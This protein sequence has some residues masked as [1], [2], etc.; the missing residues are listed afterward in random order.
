M[1]YPGRAV[2]Q[3]TR[4]PSDC[5]LQ[6][7]VN[8]KDSPTLSLLV[9][10]GFAGHW[11]RR[12]F[13]FP[14]WTCSPVPIPSDHVVLLRKLLGSAGSWI[15][16]MRKAIFSFN[17]MV[18]LLN[19]TAFRRRSVCLQHPP[20]AMRLMGLI[21][22]ILWSIHQEH[23]HLNTRYVCRHSALS[24]LTQTHPFL[25]FSVCFRHEHWKPPLCFPS[26]N[27]DSG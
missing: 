22:L 10:F 17:N 12:A 2:C 26:L 11:E 14:P 16:P 19:E 27:T 1:L 18:Y 8:R 9:W 5:N 23:L 25:C 21:H 4:I 7:H 13:S 15:A 24:H 3:T 6:A 20:L